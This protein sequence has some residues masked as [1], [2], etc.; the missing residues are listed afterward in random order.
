MVFPP[1]DGHRRA[2]CLP[3]IRSA[4]ARFH[5]W[6]APYQLSRRPRLTV[7]ARSIPPYERRNSRMGRILLGSRPFDPRLFDSIER[8][9]IGFDRRQ[10]RNERWETC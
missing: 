3:S 6:P 9:S 8:E 1:L 2:V 7:R 4:L 10:N 5:A